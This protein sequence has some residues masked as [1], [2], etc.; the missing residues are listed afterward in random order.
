M[1]SE[2]ELLR[3]VARGL[4]SS[5]LDPGAIE[6]AERTEGVPPLWSKLAELEWPL[7]GMGHEAEAV[8]QLA[9]VLEVAGRH[10]A[11][12][13]LL[14]TGLA[15]WALG[16]LAASLDLDAVLTVAADDGL[17]L[18]RQGGEVAVS[19]TA[20]RV[21]C[22]SQARAI[23]AY[24]DGE[25]VLVPGG[26]AGVAIALGR[27]L[28][29]E[30]RDEVSFSRAPGELVEGAPSREQITLRGALA[31]SAM[32][33]GAAAAV[34]DLTREHVSTRRQFDRPLLRLQVVGAHLAT[35]A[36]ECALAQA[37][38]EAAVDAHARGED[39]AW[40]TATAKLATAR[41]ATTVSRLAHQLHGAIGMTREHRLQLWTRRLWSWRQ[42]AGAEAEWEARLGA[43]VLAAGE[44]ALWAF[45][46]R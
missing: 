17:R 10:A 28:A 34:H 22:A 6:S 20:R 25:A 36:I 45:V 23:L 24:A 19:G 13:P 33:L 9:A 44:D 32:T 16:P 1:S 27:N 46:T 12:V 42:E 7:I 3:D 30:P 37:A 29:G 4:L 39:V 5:T 21:P 26:A 2:T 40:A 14:E 43:G 15:R 11:P 31:R 18:E 38:V 41:A 35:M 8:E